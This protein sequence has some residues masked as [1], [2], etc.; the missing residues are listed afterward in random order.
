MRPSL[1]GLIFIVSFSSMLGQ[2]GHES[3]SEGKSVLSRRICI[4]NTG[5]DKIRLKDTGIVWLLPEIFSSTRVPA[6]ISVVYT[7]DGNSP[8]HDY[9]PT[10]LCLENILDEVVRVHQDYGW[11]IENEVVNV[12]PN[13]DSPV[14]NVRVKNFAVVDV[15]AHEALKTLTETNEFRIFVENQGLREG[16]STLSRQTQRK[17]SNR[18]T[19]ELYNPSVREVLNEIVRQ[20]KEM[21]WIYIESRPP[22]TSDRLAWYK[23]S[24]TRFRPK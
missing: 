1:I 5:E 12:F 16:D 13:V 19:M 9:S 10:R 3:W 22:A 24:L 15:T 14:L 7:N 21:V 11:K 8:S 23:L 6:G 2:Q 4:E 18:V 17:E 20:D